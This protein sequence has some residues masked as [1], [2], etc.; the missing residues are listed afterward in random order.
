MEWGSPSAAPFET[1]KK[2]LCP[3]L[4]KGLQSAARTVCTPLAYKPHTCS[5]SCIFCQVHAPTENDQ[6][7]FAACG[8]QTLRGFFDTLEWGSPYGCP[9][10][11]SMLP[12]QGSRR[13]PAFL[14]SGL[15]KKKTLK[16][17]DNP[18]FLSE[19]KQTRR[20]RSV[21]RKEGGFAPHPKPLS[22]FGSL[23][24]GPLKWCGN[25]PDERHSGTISLAPRIYEGGGPRSGRGSP[26]PQ[27]GKPPQSR[28]RRASS[29]RGEAEGASH[30]SCPP[31]LC[32]GRATQWQGESPAA[33]GKASSVTASPCQLPQRGSRGRFAPFL[34]PAFMRGEGHAVAG[35]VP[36]S[37]GESLLSH[38]FAVPAPPEGKPRALRTVPAPRIYEGGGPRS[39]RGS[40]P[41][42]RR[43]KPPQSRLRRASSPG[44]EAEGASHRSCQF[45]MDSG[46]GFFLRG[47]G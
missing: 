25:L 46:P 4:A 9:I 41:P 22:S 33:A 10:L 23:R 21:C 7:L 19:L 1:A 14:S 31:H 38:G 17:T 32:G 36:R 42:Q 39:G 35:G 40:P 20:K 28:L 5:L 11:K 8:R 30:R 3:F 29:P 15:S 34:P 16:K 18:F 2:G 6:N 13:L 45:A 37:G 24:T 26:P 44:G 43:G 47:G 27:R 12:F